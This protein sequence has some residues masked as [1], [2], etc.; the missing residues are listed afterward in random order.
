M[1]EKKIALKLIS[2]EYDSAVKKFPPF[3]NQH[4]GFAVIKEE[5]DELW[6]RVKNNAPFCAGEEA[7]QVGAMAVRFLT[8]CSA[9][10]LKAKSE[11][12]SNVKR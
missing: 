7:I 6:D 10:L 2:D 5:L 1:S 3:N 4:E 11:M 8:D 12:K 9:G